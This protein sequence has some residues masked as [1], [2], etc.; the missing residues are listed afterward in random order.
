MTPI[1]DVMFVIPLH[2]KSDLVSR[3]IDS[4]PKSPRIRYIVV[5]PK[6][7]EGW[8]KSNI[9]GEVI[10]TE[11]DDKNYSYPV[12]V[13]GGIDYI[14]CE[15]MNPK[16]ISILEYDDILSPKA[17]EVIK[18]YILDDEPDEDHPVGIYAPLATVVQYTEGED[19]P[20]LMGISNEA[21]F[22][23]QI[24][25]EDGYFD[26]NMMLKTNFVFVNGCFIKPEVFDEFG[27]FKT[28]FQMFYD[29]EWALRM[30]YNG[31]IIK[32]VP[33][34]THIHTARDD[35]AFGQFVKEPKETR[36]FWLSLTRKEYFFVEEREIDVTA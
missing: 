5:V 2:I 23:P 22:A 17:L 34:V 28:N 12:L 30:V 35:G 27:L 33:K 11:S 36:D 16:F 25:E 18:E 10:V 19:K 6:E 7:I 1:I 29:Y 3:A 21:T 4:I 14:K 31:V 13:N 15:E 20:T 24:A 9:T 26:F 8:A 32:S